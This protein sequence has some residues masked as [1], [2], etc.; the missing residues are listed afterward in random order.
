MSGA[1]SAIPTV[2]CD[3]KCNGQPPAGVVP[4]AR[5]TPPG[6]HDWRSACVANDVTTGAR[7]FISLDG[8]PALSLVACWRTSLMM[9]LR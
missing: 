1:L 3:D 9:N 8:R 7:T 2:P 6:S 4:E 5:N